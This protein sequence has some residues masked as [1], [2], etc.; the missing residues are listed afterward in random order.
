M[1]HYPSLILTPDLVEQVKALHYQPQDF[2]EGDIVDRLYEFASYTLQ[3]RP[4][5]DLG[6]SPFYLDWELVDSYCSLILQN[7]SYPPVIF[8]PIERSLIDGGHRLHAL[9]RLKHSTVLCYVG[10]ER[11]P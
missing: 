7:P 5:E 3:E 2:D 10:H 8:N 11:Y 4:I 9:L 6:H 1:S